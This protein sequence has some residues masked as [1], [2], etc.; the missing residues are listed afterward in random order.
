MGNGGREEKTEK[1][2]NKLRHRI[3]TQQAII[4]V[5]FSDTAAGGVQ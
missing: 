2:L 4:V 1:D 3:I 5:Y